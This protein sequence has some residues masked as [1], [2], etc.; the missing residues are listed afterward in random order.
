M[1]TTP[2]TKFTPLMPAGLAPNERPDL[3]VTVISQPA[4]VQAFHAADQIRSASA[5]TQG[6]GHGPR[7]TLQRDNGRVSAIRIQCSCGRTI[8]LACIYETPPA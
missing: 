6:A 8:E 1:Q 3:R 5:C 4:N 2:D 7:V